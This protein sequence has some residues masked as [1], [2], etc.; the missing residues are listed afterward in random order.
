MITGKTLIEWGFEPGPY[1]REAI[2]NAN[3][4]EAE[5]YSQEQIFGGVMTMVPLPV[6]TINYRTNA[7]PYNVFLEPENDLERANLALV[8][9]HMDALMRVPTIVK[10]AV[11]PDACP[12]GSVEGTIPVGGVVACEN[13]IHPGF[14]SADICCS[15]AI[16]V[17]KRR[18]G[19]DNL[20]ET[21]KRL[22]H[23]GPGRREKLVHPSNEL[24]ERFLANSFLRDLDPSFHMATQGDGNHF[25]FVGT[26]ESAGETAI[27][28]HHGSR[29]LGATLYKRGMAV[30]QRHTKIVAPRVPLHQAWLPADSEEG[31]AY[32]EALQILRAWTKENH[33]AIH[34][35][36]AR[37]R[38]NSV[39]QRFWNEHN[40]VF[41]R[42]DGLYYHAK[43]ATPSFPM[44]S[45][46]DTGLTLIPMNMASPILITRHTNNVDALGFAPHGAGRN[47]GR[48]AFLRENQELKLPEG[49]QY[50]AYLGTPDLSELP[51]AYK[52]AESVER[53]ITKFNLA[54]IVDRVLP[55]ATIMA[56]E[57]TRP[58]K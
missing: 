48:K 34:D 5:G 8:N 11:M 37:A 55:Y 51:D 35:M 30:A 46:D 14:H 4:L 53:Q 33:F 20:F 31:R 6:E 44:F 23:F 39:E 29:G 54:E 16:S 9:K 25:L 19:L 57:W 13:A 12:S 28:T 21:A 41:K 17:F 50:H 42:R 52:N 24:K 22:T 36:I 2:A 26:L 38:G 32:W 56:G 45:A 47:L 15:M 49:I 3:R 27:V 1:F 18:G 40:F 43:G 7:L 10:A 58:A